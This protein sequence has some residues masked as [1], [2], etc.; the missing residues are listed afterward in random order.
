MLKQTDIYRAGTD[1]CHTYRIPAMVV[2]KKGTILA[3]CEARIDSARDYGDIDLA[4]KRSFDNGESWTDMQIIW[5][6][7][8]NTIGNPCPVVDQDTGTI[9]LPF[10]R[11]SD[12]VF[13]T[14]S[15]DEGTTWAEPVE[16]TKDVKRPDWKWY[17]TGPT[18]GVQLKSG[19]LLIPCDH[20][21]STAPGHQ[22][23]SHVIYSD[24]H[25][26]TWKLGGVLR[27]RVNECVTVETVGGSLY[28]NMRS[29]HEK[30]R[31]ACAWS[32]DGGE[33]WS[34]IK[35][36]ET[37][38]EPV[39]QASMIR[40]TEEIHHDKNRVLF[41]NPATTERKM[42][43]IRISRDECKTWDAGKVLYEGPSA[44]SDLTIAPDMTICC[45]YERGAE[46]PYEKITFARFTLEWLTDGTDSLQK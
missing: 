9:W 24:D 28:I 35:L 19:R 27:D 11:N 16:I 23:R 42:M 44:Y 10:C 26:A 40:Y 3:F 12:R 36:D 39:C 31:R 29:Y 13:V 2:S 30:N 41:S 4:L 20:S 33:T 18:H 15:D 14:R 46:H 17:A 22:Y 34:E 38:V 32:E 5:D 8:E 37:L 43:T 1:G 21:N 6:D 25:G 7:G 45:L